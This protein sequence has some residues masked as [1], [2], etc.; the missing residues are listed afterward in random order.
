MTRQNL[1][2]E[3]NDATLSPNSHEAHCDASTSDNVEIELI[4]SKEQTSARRPPGEIEALDAQSDASF[5]TTDN[6]RA[7]V[8]GFLRFFGS[9]F[10]AVVAF[11]DPGNLEADIQVG[12]KA[13]YSLLWWLGLCT[14]LFAFLFQSL[15]AR[16]GLVTGADLAQAIGKEWSKSSRILLWVL[17]EMSIVAADIQETV[18]CAIAVKSLSG[19][20]VPLWAGC[21]IVSVAAMALLQVDRLGYRHLEFVCTQPSS[22]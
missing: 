13:R 5:S 16:L 6:S 17:L 1:L 11:L 8:C 9:G 4:R 14:L 19:G 18:G 20:A 3:D 10:L 2:G 15:S 22:S 12:V 7:T 21:I